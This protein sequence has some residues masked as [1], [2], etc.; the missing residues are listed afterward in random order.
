MHGLWQYLAGLLQPSRRS[1]LRRRV[2]LASVLDDER[3]QW[4][5]Y[6][7]CKVRYL[8]APCTVVESRPCMNTPGL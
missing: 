2:F 3:G 5:G 6:D 4:L 8:S 1:R 7:P